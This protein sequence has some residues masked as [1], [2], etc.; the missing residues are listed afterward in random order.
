MTVGA[1]DR[2][3]GDAGTR[4][5]PFIKA[6]SSSYLS[7]YLPPVLSPEL[8]TDQGKHSAADLNAKV[9]TNIMSKRFTETLRATSEP[10]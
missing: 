10:G 9:G 7:A 3:G 8:L 1:S 2:R 4:G 6:H 5:F